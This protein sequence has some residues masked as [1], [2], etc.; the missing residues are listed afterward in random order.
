MA[1]PAGVTVN[2]GALVMIVKNEARTKITLQ[3]NT[4]VAVFIGENNTVT[5]ANGYSL[6]DGKEFTRERTEENKDYFYYGDYWGI[7]ASGSQTLIVWEEE[8]IR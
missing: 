8:K 5:T 7:I 4:G 1:A 2:T 6:A 3:N